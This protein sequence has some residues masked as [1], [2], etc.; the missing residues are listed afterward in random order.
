M[1]YHSRNIKNSRKV[2]KPAKDFFFLCAFAPLRDT[3]GVFI[4]EIGISSEVFNLYGDITNA[5]SISDEILSV[6]P[7]LIFALG[8][9]AY[10]IAKTLTADHPDIPV[11]F[12][13]VINWKRYGLHEEQDNIVGIPYFPSPDI[14]F[15]YFKMFTPDVQHIGVIY[16]KMHSSEIVADAENA[17]MQAELELVTEPIDESKDLP[18]YNKITGQIDAFWILADPVVYTPRNMGWLVRRCIKDNIACFGQSKNIV[19]LGALLAVTYDNSNIGSQA[20]S[21]AKKILWENESLNIIRENYHPEIRIFLNMKTAEKIGLEISPS[22]MRI[23]TDI[24][25]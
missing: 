23:A 11:I 5:G 18:A 22:A 17:A 10:Y 1:K 8:A 16:S 14:Q 13:M 15:A 20:A 3:F 25:E 19:K 7:I 6:N 9:K 24:I 12:G 2:A 21:I 4:A